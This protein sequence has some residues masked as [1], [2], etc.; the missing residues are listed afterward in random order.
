MKDIIVLLTALLLGYICFVTVGL[1]LVKVF[2]PVLTKEELKR[3]RMAL[4]R[5]RMLMSAQ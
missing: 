4:K 3:R 1:F 5:Q 2:F